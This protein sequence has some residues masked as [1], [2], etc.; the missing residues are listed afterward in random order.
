MFFL[1]LTQTLILSLRKGGGALGTLGFYV[2]VF[3]LFT[4]AM[5]QEGIHRYALP[6]MCVAL[7]LA[8]VVSLPLLYERD[9][10]DGMLEQYLLAPMALELLV[11]AKL[12][13]QWMVQLLPIVLMLPLLGIMANVT[14]QTN[15]E[16][17][18]RLFLISPSLIAVGSLT[19]ALTLGSKRGGVLPALI[20]L[21][22]TIPLVIFGCNVAGEGA[23]LMLAAFALASVPLACWLSAAILRMVD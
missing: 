7:L 13:G 1:I 17:C 22:L 19:A 6:V 16:N 20:S 23:M 9:F 15:S 12:I 21:P 14:L 2:L 8:N 10:E 18:L 5:G 3:T 11:L 4:F